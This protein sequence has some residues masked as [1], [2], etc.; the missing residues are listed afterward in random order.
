[1]QFVLPHVA[2]LTE[3]QYRLFLFAQALVFKQ[4]A[5]IL[6]TPLDR[7]VAE[8]ASVVAA[9]LETSGKGI[10]YEHHAES[11]PAQRLASEL[12]KGIAAVAGQAG[13]EASRV[14]RDAAAALR[15]LERVA[16]DAAAAVPDAA[17]PERSW[18]AL[19]GRMMGPASAGGVPPSE[20]PQRDESPRIILP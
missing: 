9:T 8:A 18:I 15:R 19:A 14:E 16:R 20:V 4:D 17:A 13:A 2:D 7:D 12:H 1:M 10:I 3:A 11:L 5:A 6:P